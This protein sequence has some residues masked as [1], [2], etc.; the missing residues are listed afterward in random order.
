VKTNKIWLKKICVSCIAVVVFTIILE[1]II[2]STHL[3]GARISWS[4]PEPVIVYRFTP[5]AT[6]WHL[7]EN[8]HPITGKINKYGWRDRD[9]SILKPVNTVRIAVL[10]DS[11]V[12]SF[13]IESNRTFLALTEMILNSDKK[14]NYELMNF[15]ISGATQTEELIIIENDVI[16]FSPDAVILFFY[17]N[18]DIDDI[19]KTTALDKN[20]PFFNISETGEL[21]LDTTFHDSKE[22][23][24]KEK[25]NWIKQHSI[26]ISL[27]SERYNAFRGGVRFKKHQKKYEISKKIIGSLTLCTK[28]PDEIY[29]KNYELNK[30]I[31]G[32]MAEFC[33]SRNIQFIVTT[34]PI[35]PNYV[36][37]AENKYLNRDISFNSRF[38]E[39]DL[40]KYTKSLHVEY[41]ELVK[42]FKK[43]YE[44]EH[45]F[46]NWGNCEEGNCEEWGH[47]NYYGHELVARVLSERLK[48]IFDR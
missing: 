9:W 34:V 11:F 22:F 47:W 33:L 43:K 2:R 41:I 35:P 15:G 42:P 1:I 29:L 19:A 40:E 28:N 38:F 16:K 37:E 39:D 4:K 24:I 6:Y 12:E 3:F 27:I 25:I 8:N 14:K 7:K 21:F 23:K 5:N 13:Q 45:I 17:S 36:P 44:N 48:Q 20:K 32:K 30:R 31:I 18:N 46:L 10:G 26:I